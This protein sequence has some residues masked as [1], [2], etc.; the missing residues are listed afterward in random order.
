MITER[1]E[2]ESNE[3][4]GNV[5]RGRDLIADITDGFKRGLDVS[6]L[7][8]R[9]VLKKDDVARNGASD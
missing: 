4:L 1:N 7:T 6:A 9:C 8:A 2:S 5:S 3:I